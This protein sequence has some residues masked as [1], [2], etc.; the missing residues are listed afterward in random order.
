MVE[1]NIDLEKYRFFKSLSEDQKVETEGEL[2]VME[3]MR[4]YLKTQLKSNSLDSLKDGEAVENKIKQLVDEQ[5]LWVKNR[6]GFDVSKRAVG[7]T[8]VGIHDRDSFLNKLRVHGQSSDIFKG[9]HVGPVR[10]IELL[11][12]DRVESVFH[13]ASHELIHTIG[14]MVIKVDDNDQEI[15]Q[16]STGY[17]S[18]NGS[19]TMLNEMVV[20]MLNIEFLDDLRTGGKADYLSGTDIGYGTVLLMFEAFF[21]KVA[22]LAKMNLSELMNDLYTGYLTGDFSKLRIIDA[23]LGKGTL[24]KIVDLK[25]EDFRS[26]EKT[27]ALFKDLGVDLP[28]NKMQSYN[29][30]EEIEMLDGIKIKKTN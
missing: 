16:Q 26:K 12:Q 14:D 29:K 18:K 11:K 5:I 27:I 6:F 3:E 21:K 15:I 30:G 19:F 1:G 20:E 10:S 28:I 22:D 7:P 2:S 4:D 9:F 13:S 17:N 25:Y 24:K 23:T 8:A